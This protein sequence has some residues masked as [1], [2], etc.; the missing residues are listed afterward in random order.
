[1]AHLSIWPHRLFAVKMDASARDV[2]PLTAGGDLIANE[3]DHLGASVAQRHCQRP[4]RDRADMLL[5]LRYRAPV[6]RPVA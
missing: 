4:T 5:E 2:Q 3:I 1:M 6:E